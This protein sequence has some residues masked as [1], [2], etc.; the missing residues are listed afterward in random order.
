M[1]QKIP[2][3]KV[4]QWL[5]T[6][7]GAGWTDHLPKPE[8]H[9]YVGSIP[10]KLLRELSGVSRRSLEN[11]AQQSVGGGYQRNHESERSS[12]IARYI[13]YGYP[14]STTRGEEVVAENPDLVHPGW[15]PTSI[16]VNI[17]K[18]EES[19][20]RNGRECV[21]SGTHA[22]R[23]EEDARGAQLVIPQGDVGS[24]EPLEIIDG[25]HRIFAVDE[26]AGLVDDYDVPVVFFNG[27][28]SSWQAYLFWVINVEPKKI[29]PSLAFDLYPELRSQSWLERG[30]GL[31]IYQEHRA[32]ELSEAMW[33]FPSSPWHKRIELL[34]N[35]VE[36]HV[37]NAAFIR[38]LMST[39]V[40]RW[41][42]ERRLGGLFGS[43]GKDN[44]ERVLRWNRAQ[45]AAFLIQAW[46]EVAKS[47]ANSSAKW[48]EACRVSYRS[49][50]ESTAERI[51]P[52]G[53]DPAFAGPHTLLATDQ[54][55]RAVLFTFN[56]IFQ[57]RSVE[58]GLESWVLDDLE[59]S[60]TD[61]S[62]TNALVSLKRQ[63]RIHA[64]MVQLAR[65]MTLKDFDWRTSKAAG[66]DETERAVQSSYRGSSGY[67]SLQRNLLRHLVT[68]EAKDIGPA[69]LSVLE[70]IG[71]DS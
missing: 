40:R 32:Q 18:P 9:F 61:D 22:L 55:V 13:K 12:K 49:V 39:F 62:V 58:L 19:R 25:Q 57:V 1:D 26:V 24:V 20:V 44:N 53:L 31:K 15:L 27:L 28:T 6:W 42:G 7:E 63:G 33:R 48:A 35:R 37:S 3:L 5:A 30:E 51:N 21:L 59:S 56:A 41:G 69:A 66:L 11:R 4:R 17:I 2:L 8:D 16:L 54:G 36:G 38:S 23:I 10:I 14:V 60:L 71:G 46:D 67:S 70:L 68:A 50:E 43:T 64:F 65:E 34:G 45:Q 52:N 29:N 47:T